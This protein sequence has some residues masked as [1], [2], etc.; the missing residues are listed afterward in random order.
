MWVKTH[1]GQVLSFVLPPGRAGGSLVQW[2][3][4]LLHLSA[5][6]SA[7][8]WRPHPPSR[9]SWQDGLVRRKADPSLSSRAVACTWQVPC[10]CPGAAAAVTTN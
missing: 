2:A 10:A 7:P 3:G 4:W 6:Q 1:G 8:W 9:G 5:L